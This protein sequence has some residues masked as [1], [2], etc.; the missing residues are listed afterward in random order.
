VET[1]T[2]RLNE[3]TF[4]VRAD[5][6]Q[7]FWT[8]I[9]SGQ[10]EPETFP[11]FR[12]FVTKDT[13]VLDV[14]CW[15][16]PTLL[17]A[18][19]LAKAVHGFEADPVAFAGLQRNLAA[20]PE[21]QNARIYHRCIADKAGEVSFGSRHGGGDTLSSMRF[22]GG[23]TVWTVPSVRLDEFARQEGLSAPLFIK[24]DT[25]GGEYFIVPSLHPFFRDYRPTLYLSLHPGSFGE[26]A[27]SFLSKV[28][29]QFG[30][31][32]ALRSFPFLYDG[33]GQRIRL[34]ELLLKKR[35]RE[36]GAIIATHQAWV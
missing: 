17:F 9:E 24:M 20:N 10:W 13:T 28:R 31:V 35:W 25:E 29:A 6:H 2:I 33:D 18:A 4:Q 16:G 7:R 23:K 19:H 1:R 5:E 30:L 34:W 32:C 26:V 12:R 22:S 8:K 36:N 27:T 21:I 3:I 14:G 11:I 15:E